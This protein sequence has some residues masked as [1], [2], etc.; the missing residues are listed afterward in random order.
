MEQLG[1]K[2]KSDLA[3]GAF[4]SILLILKRPCE[5]RGNARLLQQRG[6]TG[7]GKNLLHE[8]GKSEPPLARQKAVDH[9][10]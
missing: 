3:G 6:F 10:R 5:F 4:G 7:H 9:L 2:E 8:P 1:E